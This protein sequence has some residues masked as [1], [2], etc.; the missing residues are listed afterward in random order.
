M[1]HIL[2]ATL[3]ALCLSVHAADPTKPKPADVMPPAAPIT[4]EAGKTKV[5]II[6]GGSS[7]D[8]KKW[9]EEYDSTFLKAA[10]FSV[11]AT[12]NS[13]Q[14]TE[15]LK[16]ADVAIISTNRNGFDTPEYRTA[17]FDFI[18]KGKGVIMLHPGTWYGFPKWPEINAKIVGGGAHGHDAIDKFTVTVLKKEHPVMAGVPA[19]FEAED[20][21]YYINAE[22]AKIPPDT[23][24]VEVLAQTSPSKKYKVSH[25]SVWVTPNDKA[26]IVGVALGHD[27]RVHEMAAYQAI[28]INAVKWTSGK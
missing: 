4:W 12:E 18:A 25:P 8:F 17:L 21:L 3:L 9:F 16:N 24:L 23:M 10:G 6:A 7:H 1:K 27:G 15:E 26:K 14:A 11:N 22:F 2:T 20:E 28:L 5:L 13:Q 19:T